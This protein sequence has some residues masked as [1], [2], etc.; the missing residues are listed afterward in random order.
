[1][2]FRS[3]W[4]IAVL[5]ILFTIFPFLLQAQVLTGLDR[6]S[7][8]AEMF[9]NKRLGIITN[10][11][12]YT[13]DGRYITEVFQNIPG[14]RIV[15]LFGPEHGIRG[16]AAAGEK[17]ASQVNPLEGIPI[18]SLYGKTRKPTPQMLKGIDVLV[19]DIQDIGARYYTYIST[20]GLA[21]EAAA[22]QGIPFVVLDRPNP[23]NGVDVEGNCLDTTFRS[24]VGMYPIPERHGLTV[25]ELARMIN[26]EGWLKNGIRAQ[27]TVIPMKNWK[28]RMWFDETGLKFRKTSPNM[29]D[30]ET[31]TLYPGL[32]LIEATNVSEGRGTYFPFK[33]IGAPWLDG[34]KLAQSLN[35][36]KLPGVFFRDTSFVP[37]EIPGMALH[38][39][40]EGQTC[41]GVRIHITDRQQFRPFFTGLQILATLRREY[42]DQFRIRARA[43]DRLAGTDQ[44]RLALEKGEDLTK[45]YRRWEKELDSYKRLKM[46]YQL[47]EE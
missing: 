9:Q 24:F 12:A 17:V 38:P 20:M 14:A 40:Y 43:M 47:Y 16:S 44:L 41:S 32:C 35:Q 3:R 18:Y 7:E 39:K 21:M 46:K 25:G 26:G 8:F 33:V 15:A 36:L 30:L 19:F 42:P 29:P 1:M 13:R 31:A 37:H 11:T 22:E 6:V 2:K 45:L 4:K 5:G 28:R 27:L 10:H 23:I 34:H